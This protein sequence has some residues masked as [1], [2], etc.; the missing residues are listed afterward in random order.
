MS[1]FKRIEI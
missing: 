1:N